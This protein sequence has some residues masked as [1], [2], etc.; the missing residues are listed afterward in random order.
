MTFWDSGYRLVV[1]A[2]R[3]DELIF[4]VLIVW[5]G[6]LTVCC[7]VEWGCVWVMLAM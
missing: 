7:A 1:V 6:E 3:L 2:C 4:Q 5:I